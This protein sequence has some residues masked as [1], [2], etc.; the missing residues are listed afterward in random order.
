LQGHLTDLRKNNKEEEK[1]TKTSADIAVTL[2]QTVE[3]KR[4]GPGILIAKKV[5]KGGASQK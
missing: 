1:T 4:G 5:T 2:K 3:G